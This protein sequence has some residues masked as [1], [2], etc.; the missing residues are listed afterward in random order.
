MSARQRCVL[1][2]SGGLDTSVAVR[3][4]QEELG[5]D[6]VTLTAD[7]GGEGRDADDVTDARAARRRAWPRTSSTRAASSSSTS[8]FPRSPPARC[9]RACTRWPPRWPGRSSPSCSSRWPARR[10]RWRWPTAAPARATTRCASTSPPRRS[11]PSS[12]WSPRCATGTWAAREEIAYAAAHGIE[13]PATVE[14][15]YSVD[16][17][18]W[19]RSV[20]CGPLEDP[21]TEPPEEVFAWTADPAHVRPRRARRSP[22]VSSHGVPVSRRR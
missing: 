16:A 3:W 13:V 17:N 12:R 21:W 18:L 2:Y 9:T 19:G 4:L 7:L 22:S 5:Y 15:P 8:S 14:S 11:P 10:A 6:V 20:E 1:A